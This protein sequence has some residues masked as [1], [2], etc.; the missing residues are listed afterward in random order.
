MDAR[1][2]CAGG[3]ANYSESHK[4]SPAVSSGTL[5]NSADD[6]RLQSGR[7][8]ASGGLGA[9][10]EVEP[11]AL[12]L[13]LVPLPVLV[14]GGSLRTCLAT[15]SQHFIESGEAAL[16]EA[17]VV[18]KGR[19]PD[20][21]IACDIG[22]PPGLAGADHSA[23]VPG[24]GPAPLFAWLAPKRLSGDAHFRCTKGRFRP[25]TKQIRRTLVEGC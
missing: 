15:L 12:E 9:E 2:L 19:D 1:C 24:Q 20:G 5:D 13:V 21:R 25:V 6:H 11:V 17:V 23:R 10:L 8:A 16:G 4:E 3:R 14:F 7:P 22:S 18:R